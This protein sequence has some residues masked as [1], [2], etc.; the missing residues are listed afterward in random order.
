MA[1]NREAIFVSLNARLASVAGMAGPCS[2]KWASY[3]DTPP[4][5]QPA[6]FLAAGDEQAGGDRRQPTTWTLRP[7]LILY[8]RNDAD[9]EAAPSTQQNLLITAI[10]AKL[11][12]TPGEAMGGGIFTADSDAPHTTLGGLVSSCR[13][14][15][16]VVK[17]EGLFQTQ[18]IVEIPLEIITTA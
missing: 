16:T 5:T 6:L 11:E 2:R 4:E 7:K 9:P 3:S 8:T 14:F 10:E 12:L 1:L 15:G 17:D 18:G 13:I